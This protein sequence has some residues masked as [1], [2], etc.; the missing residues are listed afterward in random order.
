MQARAT[1]IRRPGCGVVLTAQG[2]DQVV[3]FVKDNGVGFSVEYLNKLF[4]VM[5]CLYPQ[6]AF[7]K[8]GTRWQTTL[9]KGVRG[10][11]RLSDARCGK[12]RKGQNGTTPRRHSDTVKPTWPRRSAKRICGVTE[13]PRELMVSS[14]KG[15]EIFSGSAEGIPETLGSVARAGPHVLV[16]VRDTGPG[17]KPEV[18]ERLFEAFYTTKPQGLGM[19]LAI[20][21]SIIQAHGGRLWARA[22]VPRGAAFAFALPIRTAGGS[23]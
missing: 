1:L 19:G 22:N 9:Q 18:L 6:E 17:L 20:S 7:I 14:Q 10:L 3:V 8:K 12:L 11:C 16:T 13:G 15:T 21:R 4:C 5:Q 23:S 2:H